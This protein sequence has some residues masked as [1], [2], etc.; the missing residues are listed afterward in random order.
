MYGAV[1]EAARD[2]QAKV[3]RRPR[4]WIPQGQRPN[5]L[6][7]VSSGRARPYADIR[8]RLTVLSVVSVSQATRC[9]LAETVWG[10][11]SAKCCLRLSL[12]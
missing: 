11:G 6:S 10:A 8:Y 9:A 12:R 7:C 2:M 1:H 5:P 4:N 3:A